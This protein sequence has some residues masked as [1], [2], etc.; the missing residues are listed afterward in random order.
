VVVKMPGEV[1][2][3]EVGIQ[4][5]VQITNVHGKFQSCWTR[6]IVT[7]TARKLNRLRET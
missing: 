1:M 6:R 3:N 7:T 4:G 2:P 5:E